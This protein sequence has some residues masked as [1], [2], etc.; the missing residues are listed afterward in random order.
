MN[1]QI[2]QNVKADLYHLHPGAFGYTKLLKGI[3]YKGFN[4]KKRN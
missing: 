1:S 2:K 3:E 4:S